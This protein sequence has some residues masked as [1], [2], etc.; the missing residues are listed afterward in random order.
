V[1]NPDGISRRSALTVATV[2]LVD[3]FMKG[4]SF[5]QR[6]WE[7][8]SEVNPDAARKSLSDF[9][10]LLDKVSHYARKI[11]EKTGFPETNPKAASLPS[12]YWRKPGIPLPSTG[13]VILANDI[14][15]E[16]MEEVRDVVRHVKD[17]YAFLKEHE[18][19]PFYQEVIQ[20][21]EEGAFE[22]GLKIDEAFS[23]VYHDA[24]SAGIV[25]V[26]PVAGPTASK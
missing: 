13:I 4:C 5:S 15:W 3:A 9:V 20:R 24:V 26:P 25:R 7:A 19:E 21:M 12:V 6:R 14:Q 1:I 2:L 22:G 16:K 17:Y 8:S 10:R 18:R 11:N 23:Q